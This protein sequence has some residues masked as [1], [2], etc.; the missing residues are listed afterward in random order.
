MDLFPEG[1]YV[2]LMV[3]LLGAIEDGIFCFGGEDMEYDDDNDKELC[4]NKALPS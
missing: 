3:P 1:G 2:R 4:I